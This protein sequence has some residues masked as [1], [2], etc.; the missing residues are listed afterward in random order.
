QN[1]TPQKRPIKTPIIKTRPRTFPSP[2]HT[3]DQRW[4][5]RPLNNSKAIAMAKHVCKLIR[6]NTSVQQNNSAN[7]QERAPIINWQKLYHT[8][9][10]NTCYE[11]VVDN[12]N[13]VAHGLFREFGWS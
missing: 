10:L 5:A 13:R 2:L 6:K 3:V 8:L 1:L 9:K 11:Y 12:L 7:T 4:G